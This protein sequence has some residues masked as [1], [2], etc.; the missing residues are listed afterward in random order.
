MINEQA[1]AK[2][3]EFK[4]K[5]N[6]LVSEYKAYVD[7]GCG[8]CKGDSTIEIDGKEYVIDDSRYEG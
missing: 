3:N 6:A 7:H 2:F 4:D 8:C 5:V 1:Q